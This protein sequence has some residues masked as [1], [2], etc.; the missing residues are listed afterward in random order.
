[1]IGIGYGRDPEQGDYII[2][3]NSWGTNWGEEG[4]GRISMSQEYGANGICGILN[5]ASF[6]SL[7]KL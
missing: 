2:I 6:A 4:F 1:M 3:K 5:E 7:E